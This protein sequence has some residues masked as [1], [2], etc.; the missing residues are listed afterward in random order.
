MGIQRSTTV[1]YRI[2]YIPMPRSTWVCYLEA[3]VCDYGQKF[4]K[5][6]LIQKLWDCWRLSRSCRDQRESSKTNINN[7]VREFKLMPQTNISPTGLFIFTKPLW[8]TLGHQASKLKE[9]QRS[10]GGKH[11]KK[12]DKWKESSRAAAERQQ[13]DG[14]KFKERWEEKWRR[15]ESFMIFVSNFSSLFAWRHHVP[16]LAGCLY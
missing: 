10:K 5:L 9:Q 4:Q 1:C 7:D 3:L 6:C 15:G 13:E 14:G 2:Y 12:E 11:Q 16:T 8:F